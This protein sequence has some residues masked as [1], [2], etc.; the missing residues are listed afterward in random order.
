MNIHAL[1]WTLALK[2]FKKPFFW[3]CIISMQKV[4]FTRL[5]L[6]LHSYAKRQTITWSNFTW[7]KLSFFTWS[8]VLINIS[9]LFITWSNYFTCVKKCDLIFLTGGRLTENQLIE[10][11]F[12]Q[13]IKIFIISWPK[14]WTLFS[15]SKNSINCQKRT[16]GFWQLIKILKSLKYHY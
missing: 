3:I 1:K 15:W 10:I 14:F 8:K 16:D 4:F 6:W 9:S 5:E 13:L 2:L 7:S 12:Y 11:V